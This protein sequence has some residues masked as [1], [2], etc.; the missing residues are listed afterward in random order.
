MYVHTCYI[1]FLL[2]R[3]LGMLI[4]FVKDS[5]LGFSHSY[6]LLQWLNETSLISIKKK[7]RGEEV[8]PFTV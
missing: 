2:S 4:I 6:T 7:K 8:I 1:S 3:L 5:V